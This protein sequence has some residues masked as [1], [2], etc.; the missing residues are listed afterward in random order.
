MPLHTDTCHVEMNALQMH[1]YVREMGVSNFL[2]SRVSVKSQL[3]IETWERVLC[4]YWD[5]QLL[6]LIKFGFPLDFNLC[7]MRISI[8]S[9]PL[10]FHM[11]S[12]HIYKRNC[13]T[14]LY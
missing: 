9:Q 10:V 5:R 2:G 13:N 14:M 12:I 8:I 6:E 11:M 3:N 7:V 1:K 4:D